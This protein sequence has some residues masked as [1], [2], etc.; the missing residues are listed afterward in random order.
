MVTPPQVTAYVNPELVR[1]VE[2]RGEAGALLHF[3]QDHVMPVELPAKEVAARL[4]VGVSREFRP[5]F[6]P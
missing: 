6:E 3:A 5:A 1:L 2:P 4:L